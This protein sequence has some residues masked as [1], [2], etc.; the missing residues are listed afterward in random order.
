MGLKNVSIM[1]PFIRTVN[2]AKTVLELLAKQDLVQGNDDLKITMMVET[3]SSVLL[4]DELCP[5]Y[6]GFSIG[7]N[8]LR[9]ANGTLIKKR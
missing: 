8:D 1:I 2:E 6:D 9:F 5:L 3:P 7:S 4:L